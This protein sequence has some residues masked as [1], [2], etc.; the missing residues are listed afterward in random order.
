MVGRG[1]QG[2]DLLDT[3]WKGRFE[4]DGWRVI[5]ASVLKDREARAPGTKR[6]APTRR[7]A[8][9]GSPPGGGRDP[10]PHGRSETWTWRCCCSRAQSDRA[11]TRDRELEGRESTATALDGWTRVPSWPCK[12]GLFLGQIVCTTVRA[13]SFTDESIDLLLSHH[14]NLALNSL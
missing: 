3:A 14:R 4:L 9:R 8:R 6:R 7:G 2:R 13:N 1:G 11:T 5:G 10:R 12:A